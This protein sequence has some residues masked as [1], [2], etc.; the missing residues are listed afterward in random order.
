MTSL[1]S[2]HSVACATLAALSLAACSSKS[3]PPAPKLHVPSPAWEDQIIYFVMTDRFAN[4][5]RSNDDQHRGEYGPSQGEK[6]S[7]GDLQGIVD[8][9]DYIEGLG[10][11]AVWITPPVANMWWDPR[12][13]SGGYHGYWARDLSAVDEHLGTLDTYKALSS[14]LHAR[15][16]YLVQDVVPNHMGNFF[17]YDPEYPPSCAAI[18]SYTFPP[19]AGSGCDLAQ[20]FVRNVDAVPTSRP[21]QPPFDLDDATDAVQLAASIY[22]WTPAI[23]DYTSANQ[24]ANYQI[25]DLDDLN[26]E[27]AV[28]RAALKRAYA[29][30]VKEVGVDAFRVDTAK[31]VPHAFWNDFFHSTDPAAPGILAVAR[32]TGRDDFLAFGEVFETPDPLTDTLERKVASYLGT[33][34]A[35]ELPSVLAFPLYAEIGRVFAAGQPTTYMTY[36]LRKLMDPT[37]YPNPYVLPTFVDN[38]DVQRFLATSTRTG[39][40]LLAALAFVFTIPGIPV[41]YYGT[42]QG[43]TE[44]RQAMFAGG[45]DPTAAPT[46]LA[47][48][49]RYDRT[50]ALYRRI[51]KLADLRKG[52]LALRRGSLDVL[53][54]TVAAGPLAYRR[55]A[56]DETILALFNTARVNALVSALDTGLPGGSVLEVLHSEWDSP[57]APAPR[58]DASGRLTMVLPH[59]AVLLLRVT[60]RSE[61]PPPPA[62]TI[63][64]GTA[65]EG[66][67]FTG[68]VTVVGTVTPPSATVRMV[69]DAN[70]GR[71]TTVPVAADGAFSAVL[72]VSSFPVGTRQHDVAFYAPS[73]GV[74]TP[75]YRFT[76]QIAFSGD[77]YAFA[78]P[79]GDDRGPAGTYTYPTDTSFGHQMDITGVTV[80]VGATT[81]NLNVTLG[82]FSAVW[83]PPL[84]FDHVAFSIYFSLPGQTSP[85]TVMPRVGGSVPAGFAWSLNQFTYG[86]QNL[87]FT[88]AGASAGAYGAP[89]VPPVVRA[90][91]ASRTVTFSYDRTVYGLAT[92]SGVRIYVTTW[93][94]DGIG[95]RLRPLCTVG[96]DWEMGGGTAGA[97]STPCASAAGIASDDPK[98]MDDL[99]PIAIP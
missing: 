1:R 67:T 13:Q 83:N 85:A 23:A 70:V 93:D 48:S 43:F 68:D 16:M 87:M 80:D 56:G 72:P 21:T 71:A 91:P 14:A 12:E 89:S 37:L 88:S 73:A 3:A 32:S 35:P 86:W 69:L 78:D 42:E 60:G 62:A 8:R 26:T 75:A 54:D 74:S 24:E 5:D 10:A 96:S 20:H 92:W 30:W 46:H 28:V 94:F 63:V 44:T 18:A 99:P 40:D 45:F 33:A 81:M 2:L 76:S 27:N 50:S 51:R 57:S 55:T 25:S 82:G 15:G 19:P 66:E 9:L 41:V 34:D 58:V 65:L 31:F 47:P 77:T 90:D 53:Y 64:V 11:T 79:T 4:G 22:H 36:R 98:V 84:G 38:H 95:G 17:T 39:E 7:G 52:S 59:Q 97:A 6:Y 29:Y 49:D 61:A